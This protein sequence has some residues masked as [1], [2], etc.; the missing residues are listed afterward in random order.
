MKEE[1]NKRYLGIGIGLLIGFLLVT[2]GIFKMVVIGLFA[3]VGYFLSYADWTP[4]GER[5]RQILGR[6]EPWE[7]DNE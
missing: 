3:V 5:I 6:S 2:V 7:R 4:V 1:R